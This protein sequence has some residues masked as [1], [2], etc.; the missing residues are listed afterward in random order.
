MFNERK[1][2]LVPEI[3]RN[4]A[5]S[6]LSDARGPNATNEKENHAASLEAIVEYCQLAL[7]QHSKKSPFK[8]KKAV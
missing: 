8:H 3:V 6:L 7:Q 5:Q 2:H 4:R 1:L